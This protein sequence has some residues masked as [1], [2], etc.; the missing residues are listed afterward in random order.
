[1]SHGCKDKYGNDVPGECEYC[2]VVFGSRGEHSADCPVWRWWQ[3]K[4]SSGDQEYPLDGLF[5]AEAEAWKEKYQC[6]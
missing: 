2:G 6:P 4:V 3:R 5:K 1:M